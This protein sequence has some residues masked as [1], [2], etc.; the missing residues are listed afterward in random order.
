M[1]NL[2]RRITYPFRINPLSG[3]VSEEADYDS[4]IRQLIR[5]VLLTARGERVCR[6]DFGVGIRRQVFA[7]LT[8]ETAAMTRTLIL[9]GLE[10]WLGRLIKVSAIN[11]SADLATLRISIEYL[12][13]SRGVQRVLNEEFALT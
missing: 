12:V 11:V 9:E 1:A 8:N 13:I 3:R 10:R 4:Y 7:P 6:P 2:E 5:Q